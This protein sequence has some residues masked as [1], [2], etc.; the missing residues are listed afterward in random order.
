MPRP[1][2]SRGVVTVVTPTV[3]TTYVDRVPCECR[4]TAVLLLYVSETV[5]RVFIGV[6]YV[7]KGEGEIHR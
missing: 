1:P 4:R 6:D 2:C 5:P 3:A 7:S